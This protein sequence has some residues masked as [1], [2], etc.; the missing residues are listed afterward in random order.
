MERLRLSID[1]R[2]TLN[3]GVKM[4]IFGLGTFQSSSGKET[5]D[6]VVSALYSGYRHIDTASAYG[7]EMDVGKAL[8]RSGVPRDDV[9]ITTKLG[10]EDQGYDAAIRA[11]KRSL[12]R[13]GLDYVDL[14]L[15]HWPVPG[16]RVQSWKAL[17]R[18]QKDGL[19]G[20]IG[21]SNFQQRHLEELLEVASIVP[22]VDQVE[23]SPF[24]YQRDLHGYCTTEGIQLEAYS[25]L[26]KGLRLS[27]MRLAD[28][29]SQY[30]KTPAQVLIRWVLQKGVVVIPK[31]I[32]KKRI[33][34]NADVFNFN[35]IEEDMD[36]L[37]SFD[38][39]LRTGWDP[40]KVP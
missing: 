37:D 9:F 11:C 26:T 39:G 1:T 16:M 15:I 6:A 35:I 33:I 31:S 19:C 30:N 20:T 7:N 12:K 10:N 29:A 2:I 40:T 22:A 23:F 21:V 18:L 34:D 4:P 32:N 8:R 14:Y 38:E 25:P 28:I 5:E 36:L 27:D 24:T 13:L 3:N 17:E